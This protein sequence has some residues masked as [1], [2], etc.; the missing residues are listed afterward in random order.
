MTITVLPLQAADIPAFVRLELEAFRTHPRMP[1][2]W[3][4]GFTS[5]L[6]AYYENNKLQ[7]LQEETSR[8]CKAKAT[9]SE[10]GPRNLPMSSPLPTGLKT[11]IGNYGGSSKSNGKRGGRR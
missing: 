10:T 5:D 8:I 1:M 11:G 7:S 6:H 4:R 9:T 2:L 3:P